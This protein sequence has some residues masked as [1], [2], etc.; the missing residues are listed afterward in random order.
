[1]LH[2]VDVLR[3]KILNTVEME[4]LQYEED[5]DEEEEN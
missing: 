5:E 4:D 3:K 2:P 1:M